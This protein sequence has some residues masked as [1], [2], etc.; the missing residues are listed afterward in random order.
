MA[1][2]ESKFINEINPILLC[3]GLFSTFLIGRH[4]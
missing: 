1:V 2:P 3:M 4:P